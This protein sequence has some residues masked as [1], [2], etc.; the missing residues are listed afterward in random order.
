[1]W[2]GYLEAFPDY[3]T[4]GTS[5]GDLEEHLQDLHKDLSSGAIPNIRRVA[6]LQVR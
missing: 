6:H 2:L 5:R 1:M 3:W 4:Q